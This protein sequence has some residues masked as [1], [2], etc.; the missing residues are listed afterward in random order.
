M[1][2]RKKSTVMIEKTRTDGRH[3][4]RNK[5][6][7]KLV[8]AAKTIM[9]NGPA[10]AVTV[11]QITREADVGRGSFYNHFSSMDDLFVSTLEDHI[12]GIGQSFGSG[13]GQFDDIADFAAWS[14][15]FFAKCAVEDPDLGWFIANN[16]KS[17]SLLKT[18][19]DPR[20]R[21]AIELGVINGRF[22]LEDPE[23]WLS[24]GS[25]STTAF[26][27]GCLEGRFDISQSVDLAASILQAAG[28][29]R[30]EAIEISQRCDPN[31]AKKASK[32]KTK[33]GE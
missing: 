28:L 27:R 16:V 12:R 32:N 6:R 25:S 24:I 30:S 11:D 19:I 18:H 26:I 2:K 15:Q 10:E 22:Q 17:Q 29:A 14:I 23:L 1:T 9:A 5:T 7:Q 3:Q 13:L 21:D 31:T 33:L 4:R 8:N 20:A